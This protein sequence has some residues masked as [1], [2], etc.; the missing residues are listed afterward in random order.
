MRIPD[1]TRTSRKRKRCKLNEEIDIDEDVMQANDETKKV[2]QNTMK[3]LELMKSEEIDES[4][5]EQMLETSGNFE[6]KLEK[7]ENQLKTSEEQKLSIANEEANIIAELQSQI[8]GLSATISDLNE[9][10]KANIEDNEKRNTKIAE[11]QNVI[12]ALTSNNKS[13]EKEIGDLNH[14]KKD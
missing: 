10:L 14:K 13:K 2:D 7:V 12:D 5:H 1:E 9:K 3:D 11:Q 8:N 6:K 4:H